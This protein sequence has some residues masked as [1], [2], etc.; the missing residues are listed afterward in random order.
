MKET[1]YPSPL[2]I[3]PATQAFFGARILP[4][5]SVVALTL[6]SLTAQTVTNGGFEEGPLPPYPGYATTTGIVG[7]IGEPTDRTGINTS[8]GPFFDNSAIPEG[9]R[10][11]L[12]QA[13]SPSGPASLKTTVTG[14]T[15]GTKYHVALRAN[16]RAG[17]ATR[18][19]V[20]LSS[21]G[22]GPEV[23]A[24]V[25][26]V[27]NAAAYVDLGYE[28]TATA[29]SQEITIANPRPATAGDNTLMIDDVRVTPS[30][31]AWDFSA[32]NG[33]EDSG[34]SPYYHYTH[35]FRLGSG[36]PLTLNGVPF[37]GRTSALPGSYTTTGLTAT[38]GFG[39]GTLQITGDSATMASVFLYDGAPSITLQ[40]LE[41][42]TQYV[43]TLY[44]A[45]WD[46]PTDA[47]PY[48][49]ATFTSSLG[50]EKFTVNLDH[51]GQRKGLKVTYTYTTD[52]LGSPVTLSYPP[53]STAVGTFHT[54]GFSNRKAQALVG[55]A[56][57]ISQQPTGAIINP[58]SDYTLHV[59]AVGSPEFS[60]QWKRNGTDLAGANGSSLVL[61]N[62]DFADSGDYSV[63]VSNG[64]GMD[65]SIVAS[66]LVLDSLAGGFTTGVDAN[67]TPLGAGAVD[68]HYTLLVN[69]QNTSS[70]T[71]IVESVLPGVWLPNSA[72]SKWIGPLA[73]TA[74]APGQ[75]IDA[76]EGPGTYVYR[77]QIDLTG[78]DAQLS[79][80][81]VIGTWATDNR[82][83][84]IR[85]NGTD[86][87]IANPTEEG[88]FGNLRQFVINSGLVAGIN[89]LDF[90]VMNT[91]PVSGYTGLRVE[92]LDVVVIPPA[93][94]L[95]LVRQPK[96][97]LAA[98][99]DTF[100][101]SVGALASAPLTYQWYRNGEPLEGET[102]AYLQ[103]LVDQPGI[104]G[105]YKVVVTDGVSSVESAI[106]TVSASN[107]PPVA[108]ADS[109]G[110]AVNTPLEISP[111]FD[112]LFNDTDADGDVVTLATFSATSTNGGTIVASADLLIYTPPLN[113][114]GTDTFSYT[115]GDDWGATS[116]AG[117]VSIV[118]T[119]SATPPG[120]LTLVL[121]PGGS[122]VTGSF[123]GMPGASYTLQ[124]SLTLESASWVDVGTGIASGAGAVE[125]IDNAPP[126][127]RAFYR[128]SYTP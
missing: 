30:T 124:R 41:P 110:T 91:D 36:E 99:D 123:T 15:P 45:G 56:P 61:D 58:G 71:A 74:T 10:V 102:G 111:S 76:G 39:P 64:S 43:F 63:V 53:I 105:N 17:T 67:G 47:T 92:S 50:G 23:N 55:V 8:A 108:V 88:A 2:S 11:A 48:R 96:G 16:A 81:R 104:A 54:S 1:Q 79:A 35:A 73:N 80:L 83:L 119:G 95:R 14:L 100:T 106:A 19:W 49:S 89:T 117:E 85:L 22:Q 6:S 5:A 84:A 98:R 44:G 112:L 24:E 101:L 62:V 52:A 18:P 118:V 57:V 93:T 82:G 59:A 78:Q 90:V 114:V 121:A 125:I 87:G 75:S 20:R 94:A 77:T 27:G 115:V 127:V 60:Y 86:T 116:A 107:N 51:Y 42:A 69:P 72:A 4:A 33:D 126:P 25:Q 29:A 28:F 46:A 3:L 9:S 70:S 13:G 37:T 97:G 122:S 34:V 120:T 128:I 66:V 103:L 109:V 65:T 7:W 21:T 32:W 26:A 38:A 113:F 40:G 68:P 12:I 31:G